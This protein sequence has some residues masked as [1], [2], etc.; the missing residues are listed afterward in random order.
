MT[1]PQSVDEALCYGWID[2]V[3]KSI[4]AER[5]VIRFTRRKPVSIWSNVNIASQTPPQN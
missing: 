4:D 2:G 3:R 1:W 5:Y